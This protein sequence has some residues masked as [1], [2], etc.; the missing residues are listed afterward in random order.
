[1]LHRK[2]QASADNYFVYGNKVL[3]LSE[4]KIHDSFP[5]GPYQ[6]TEEK[7]GMSIHKKMLR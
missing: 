7:A 4:T 2:Q 6:V 1:M 3:G 5:Q